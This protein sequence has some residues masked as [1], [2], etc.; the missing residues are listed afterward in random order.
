[1]SVAVV[2]TSLGNAGYDGNER[3]LSMVVDR[4]ITWSDTTG[5]IPDPCL[6][7][8]GS[9]IA[10]DMV[11]MKF[12]AW[13]KGTD[14]AVLEAY[15]PPY[16]GSDS[17]DLHLPG[18]ASAAAIPGFGTWDGSTWII[19]K[20]TMNASIECLGRKAPIVDLWGYRFDVHFA[21]GGA[22][23]PANYNERGGVAPTPIAVPAVV[24]RKFIAHQI[25]DYS[26]SFRPLPLNLPFAGVKHGRRRDGR[27]ALDHLS[28]GEM[29]DLVLWFRSVGGDAFTLA[30]KSPFGP[31]QPDSVQALAR[32]LEVNRVS[33]WWEASL[34]LTLYQ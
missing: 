11:D 20:C 6:L 3:D 16:A 5:G 30:S 34:D 10:H 12:T 8:L 26:R 1:M 14:A 25:Q 24:S 22:S 27:M 29:D 32:N 4:S 21:G 2:V 13:L 31:G 23:S 17:F 9:K 19:K 28:I 33:G 15:L 18:T 7:W